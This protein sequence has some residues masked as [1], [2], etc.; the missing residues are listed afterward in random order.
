MK[1]QV[2]VA[3][4]MALAATILPACGKS[5]NAAQTNQGIGYPGYTGGQTVASAFGAS[6]ALQ[7][8]QATGW[9]YGNLTSTGGVS[10]P[11]GPTYSKTNVAGDQIVLTL[12]GSGAS[13][14]G[15]AAVYLTQA[16]MSYFQM[17]CGSGPSMVSFNGTTLVA[18]N[19]GTM[20]IG[21]SVV[22]ANGCRLNF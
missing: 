19:P 9:V 5:K 11:S 13:V 21:I 1:K 20:N 12:A 10:L 8:S 7:I 18:G 3:L 6:G 4:L 15:Y 2:K 16:S 22:S 17:Y 14:T